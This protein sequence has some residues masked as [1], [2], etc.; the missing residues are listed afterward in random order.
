MELTGGTRVTKS[1]AV[2]ASLAGLALLGKGVLKDSVPS[3]M[4][5]SCLIIVALTAISMALIRTWV[6]DTTDVRN[7]MAASQRAAERERSRYIALQAALESEQGRLNRD[8][9]AAR[10]CM[11][12]DLVAE[13]EALRGEFEEK[14]ATL[15]SETMEATFH[16]FRGGK[17]ATDATTA[18]QLIQF[19]RQEQA[20]APQRERSREHGK[21]RP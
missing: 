3:T 6:S 21:V 7:A 19:P 1:T 16:M 10:Q 2:A 13:R 4:A 15:V 11:A 20:A 9:A 12:R 14:R 5:G 18:G 8:M 17:F